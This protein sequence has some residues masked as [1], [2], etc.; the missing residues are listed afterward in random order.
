MILCQKIKENIIRVLL[1]VAQDAS[2]LIASLYRCT[3]TVF[4]NI[5]QL[6]AINAKFISLPYCLRVLYQCYI[7]V[8]SH[9]F[10]YIIEIW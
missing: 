7:F 10:I 6:L 4:I 5:D 1:V 2:V 9:I 8:N 3:C